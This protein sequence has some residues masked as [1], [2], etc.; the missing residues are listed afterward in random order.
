M[1]D[2]YTLTWGCDEIVLDTRSFET[3][4]AVRVVLTKDTECTAED[5]EELFETGILVDLALWIRLE[6]V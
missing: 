4:N 6:R 2:K 5:I 1:A 3:E